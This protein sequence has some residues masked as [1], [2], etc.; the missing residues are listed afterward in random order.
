M[1][2][3]ISLQFL[4]FPETFVTGMSSFGSPLNITIQ[5]RALGSLTFEFPL[6]DFLV[7]SSSYPES[8]LQD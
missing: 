1:F 3:L 5:N 2:L 7:S 6:L 8:C 4:F